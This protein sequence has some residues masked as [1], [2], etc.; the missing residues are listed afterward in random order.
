[1]SSDPMQTV[2]D[3]AAAHVRDAPYDPFAGFNGTTSSSPN[4]DTATSTP[5]PNVDPE[6]GEKIDDSPNLPPEF[7]DARPALSSIRQ[8]AHARTVSPDAV[9]GV[10]LA[11]LAAMTP[12]S[13]RLPA[14]VGTEGTLDV[15]VALIGRSGS[16]KSSASRV[17]TELV[18]ITDD[19]VATVPLGSGEGIVE[20][21]MGEVIE[22][23]DAGKNKKVKRQVRRAVLAMLDEGQALAELGNRKGSTLLPT[24]RSAW[25]GD[26][27][28]Q[29]NASEDRRRH[30][31]PGEYRFALVAGFQLEHAVHLIDDAAGGTPQRFA[32]FAAHDPTIPDE[33]PDWPGPIRWRP[34]LHKPGAMTVDPNVAAHVRGRNL[35]R[36]RGQL[37]IDPLDAHRDLGRLKLAGLLA[38]L[39][40]RQTITVDDWDLAGTIM[41][42]SDRVRSEIIAAARWRAREAERG[43]IGTHVRRAAALD[44][45]AEQRALTGMAKAIARHVHRDRCDGCARR[46]V[47]QATKSTHRK[48]ADIDDAIDEAKRHGWITVDGDTFT[49]GETCP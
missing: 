36:T 24:I 44:D 43:A 8:A 13:L 47:T 19:N 46:C 11:R 28:G 3:R 39:D 32:W 15:A 5:P 49:A 10:V 37:I 6:T 1:M 40:A 22:V 4:D 23:D 21:Y 9:L 42:S 35:A 33:P 45:D 16:G 29:A 48:S 38:L 17:A 25:S 27:L 18:P 34:P 2:I 12:P 31:A 7:W 41:D 30:L 26:R 14:I 20:A